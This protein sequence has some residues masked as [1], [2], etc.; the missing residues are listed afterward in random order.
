MGLAR[1]RRAQHLIE[2]QFDAV[3]RVQPGAEVGQTAGGVGQHVV[4]DLVERHGQA[5]QQGRDPALEGAGQGR[6]NALARAQRR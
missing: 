3:V 5:C 6:R 4:A 2:R 1:H